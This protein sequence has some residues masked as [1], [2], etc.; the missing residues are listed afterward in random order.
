SVRCLCAQ[1]KAREFLIKIAQSLQ[2]SLDILNLFV[3]HTGLFIEG[4]DI[5]ALF[6]ISNDAQRTAFGHFKTGINTQFCTGRGLIDVFGYAGGKFLL[7]DTLEPQ[8]GRTMYIYFDKMLN[9]LTRMNTCLLVR[10]D[11]DRNSDNAIACQ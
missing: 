8:L 5:A 7:L 4:S 1:T 10:R 2:T 11:R 6:K 3:R 9:L